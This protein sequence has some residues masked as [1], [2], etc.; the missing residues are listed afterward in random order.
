MRVFMAVALAGLALGGCAM[1][2]LNEGPN[3]RT[4]EPGSIVG[5][6][7]VFFRADDGAALQRWYGAHLGMPQDNQGYAQLPWLEPETGDSYSTTWSPF[8]RDSDYFDI[9]QPYMI[10][11]IVDDLDA[12]LARLRAAGARIDMDKGVES[13]EYGRFAWFW[14]P[15]GTRVELWEPDRAFLDAARKR[16]GEWAD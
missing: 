16:G 1:S 4:R 13:Y 10:N 6:G 9:D 15:E 3:G 5:I 14:D 12:A 11:Y 7:G 8:Q 2:D